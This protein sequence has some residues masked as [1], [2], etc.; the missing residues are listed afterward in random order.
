MDDDEEE[1]DQADKK[2]VRTLAE[3]AGLVPAKKPAMVR[4]DSFGTGDRYKAAA[5]APVLTVRYRQ[6]CV[7]DSFYFTH[8]DGTTSRNYLGAELVYPVSYAPKCPCGGRY[9]DCENECPWPA[10]LEEAWGL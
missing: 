1:L 3:R 7:D 4:V 8:T 10:E 6:D 2:A 9:E 5:L